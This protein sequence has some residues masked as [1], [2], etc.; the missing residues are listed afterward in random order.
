MKIKCRISAP[1]IVNIKL[2]LLELMVS[3]AALLC[4]IVSK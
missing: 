3:A 1:K 2:D 4:A